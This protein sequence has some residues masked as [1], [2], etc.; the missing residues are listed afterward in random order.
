MSHQEM[1]YKN[2]DLFVYVASLGGCFYWGIGLV[3]AL[4]MTGG[5]LSYLM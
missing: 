5:Q 3:Y 2:Q 1:S 4:Y